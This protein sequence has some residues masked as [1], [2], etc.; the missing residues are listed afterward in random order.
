MIDEP[1]ATTIHGH[2]DT[3]AD[4][5]AVVGEVMRVNGW[6]L[7]DGSTL[8]SVELT[9]NGVS[10]GRARCFLDRPD[11]AANHSHRDAPMAGFMMFVVVDEP[12][13]HQELLV[14]VEAISLDGRRWNSATHR[15][16][17]KR[18]NDDGA[19]DC[20]YAER[21]H[22]RTVQALSDPP[23]PDHRLR[24]AVV[25]HDLG[26]GGGQLWLS[27][28][29]RQFQSVDVFDVEVISL[30]DG[31]LRADLEDAGIA[32]HVTAMPAIESPAAHEDRVREFGALL[33]LSQ[34]NAVLVNTIMPFQAVEAAHLA[35]LPVVWA[36]HESFE[37]PVY[38]HLVWGDHIHPRV[39]EQFAA[40]FGRADAL[41]FEASQTA[42]LFARYSRPERRFVVDY[43]V[44][45]GEIDAVRARLDRRAAR[46]GLGW[47]DDDIVLLVVGVVQGRKA[48]AAIV[49]AFDVLAATHPHLRLVLVGRHPSTYADLLDEQ[50]ARAAHG[51][52]VRVEPVTPDVHFWYGVADLLVCGSDVESLPRSI[53]EAMAFE[54]PVVST[55]V[56]GVATLLDDG[57]T[58]W[59]SRTGDL[60]SLVATLAHV[61][62][63]G[64][65][66]RAR[67]AA[68]ARTDVMARCGEQAYGALLAHALYALMLEQGND[69]SWLSVR[70][71]LTRRTPA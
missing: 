30:A 64:T 8:S 49:A 38:C 51:S 63:V 24:V 10:R 34:C 4:G 35:G 52:R 36:I 12:H 5:D 56:F 39:I 3:P 1:P 42:D 71:H 48:Q 19:D 14:S 65:A 69:P 11:V 2:L 25:T 27:E 59:L 31:P 21:L 62:R 6:V 44:D 47:S 18:R 55:D 53:L 67:V 17:R 33:R 22:Q 41:V 29:L 66:E 70:P 9:I 61:L 68:N 15:V 28:M 57:E 43:G 37:L 54:L 7:F 13:P 40:A 23:P 32:V 58:G 60:R 50:I 20:R 46:A 45:V 26:Y 16:I